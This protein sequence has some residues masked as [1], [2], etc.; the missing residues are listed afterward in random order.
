MNENNLM[1]SDEVIMNKIFLVRGQKVMIDSEIAE[2]YGVETRRLNEQVKRNSERFPENF[3]FQLTKDEF[4]NLK[5]QNATSSWGGRRKLP[6]V[7]T[8]HGILMLA[9]VLKS[10]RAIK[11]SIR[12]IEVF[13]KIREMFLTHKDILIRLE[14]IEESIAEHDNN[15]LVI[16]EYLKQLEKEKQ[17]QIDQENRKRIRYF[18]FGVVWNE[19]AKKKAPPKFIATVGGNI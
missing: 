13:V 11:M 3:M 15:I 7:F 18:Y 12:I 8:E 2:L 17:N 19:I 6:F 9:N 1:I 5:S 4:D 10:D 16:F 14:K